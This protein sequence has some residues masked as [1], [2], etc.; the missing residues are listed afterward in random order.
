MSRNVMKHIVHK[1]K[2]VWD[3]LMQILV[4]QNWGLCNFR[5]V[6]IWVLC[7]MEAVYIWVCVNLGFVNLRWCKSGG[8]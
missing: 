7:K 4:L 3:D 1:E 5:T 6:K 2:N 8:M